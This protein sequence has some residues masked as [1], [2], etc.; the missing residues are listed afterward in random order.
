[1]KLLS[2][3]IENFGKLSN[4]DY[5]FHD[6]LNALN[7]LNGWGKTTF[8]SF[9]KAMFYG[10][11]KRGR[12]KSYVAERSR[13][14]P[15]Q[16]G[17]YGGSVIF[18]HNEK[19]YKVL[20][21]FAQTPEGDRFELVDVKSGTISR[22]FSTRLGEEIFGVGSETFSVTTF[23][24]QGQLEGEINDEV[25]AFL[26]GV[27]G[28][29]SDLE[30]SDKAINALDRSIKN[31]KTQLPSISVIDQFQDQKEAL[32]E[33]LNELEENKNLVNEGIVARK[34]KLKTLLQQNNSGDNE[35]LNNLK[36]VEVEAKSQNNFTK[37][38]KT[39]GYVF[40]A[41][42]LGFAVA[43]GISF[44]NT[45]LLVAFGVL[46]GTSLIFALIFIIKNNKNEKERNNLKDEIISLKQKLQFE[47][48]GTEIAEQ[49][50]NLEK[51]IAVLEE[52]HSF[53]N[54]QIL[55]LTGEIEE[56]DQQTTAMLIKKKELE[57]KLSTLLLVKDFILK[58]KQN[59]SVRF[60][61]PMQNKLTQIL[62]LLTDKK[63]R[64]K[65][66]LDL[67]IKVDTSVGL[68]EKQFLS[69]GFRD[70]LEICKRFALIESVFERDC[71]FIVLDDPFVNL[72]EPTFKNAVNL[73]KKL[74]GKYQII[75]L[76]CHSSRAIKE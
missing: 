8:A 57:Y 1:M 68:M 11:E 28:L 13:F 50:V 32:N 76:T 48:M 66:D 75:Y 14:A 25:R 45:I 52:R 42:F 29:N 49:R 39:L 61:E 67:N 37:K 51:E 60:V 72:D 3:H 36:N 34:E 24:G 54:E 70:L 23:F 33:K 27:N 2:L 63:P 9:L 35:N 47:Q 12:L 21:T 7:Q 19:T 17:V 56:I 6:G 65:I 20:R 58:A 15:W 59:L 22:D 16:G 71:P 26:T 10:M 5:V 64:A 44:T 53:L 38:Y 62:S 43:C 73:I 18:E 69:Q 40:L 30:V 31:L 46:S 4:F 41:L 55:R 74:A